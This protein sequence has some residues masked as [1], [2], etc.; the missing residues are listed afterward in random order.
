MI[1]TLQLLF[2]IVAVIISVHQ[3][4]FT[5][6][7]PDQTAPVFRQPPAD[8][9]VCAGAIP[10]PAPLNAIDECEGFLIAFSTDDTTTINGLCNGGIIKR[11]WRV[12]DSKGNTT[13]YNQT[14]RVSP[15]LAPPT[16]SANLSETIEFVGSNNFGRWVI[17]KQNDIIINATDDCSVSNI[18][19]NAPTIFNQCGSTLVTFTLEDECGKTADFQVR[20]TLRDT[21]KP[22]FDNL[23]KDTTISC[24]AGRPP[25][26][27]VTA[28]KNGVPVNVQFQQ[29]DR[30]LG[31]SPCNNYQIIRTWTASDGCGNTFVGVQTITVVDDQAPTFTT[32]PNRM[33]DCNEDYTDVD[34]TGSPTNVS[35]NCNPN[36]VTIN[37]QD[38][39]SLVQQGR[40]VERTWIARD[41]C[42]N[43]RRQMQVITILDTVAP[44]FTVPADIVVDCGQLADLN[45]TG[46]PTMV[47]DNCTAVPTVNYEDVFTAGSCASGGAIQRIWQV[48][49]EAGNKTEKIQRISLDDKIPPTITT[50]A[51]DRTVSCGMA[52][53]SDVLFTEWINQRAGAV[54]VDNCSSITNLT[55]VAYNAGTTNP[56]SLSNADCPLGGSKV[57]RQQTVDFIVQDE[58][59]NRDTTRA[60]FTVVDDIAPVFVYCPPDTTI[61]NLQGLCTTDYVLASPVVEER[62]ATFSGNYNRTLTVPVFSDAPNNRDVPVNP[63]RLS[64]PIILSPSFASDDVRLSIRLINIDG[65]QGPEYFNVLLEDGSIVGRTNNTPAQCGSS[66]TVF[67]NISATQI[68]QS[69][70]SN[71]LVTFFLVPNIVEGQPGRFSVNDICGGSSVEAT[72][73]FK[74]LTPKDIRYEYQINDGERLLFIPP[75]PIIE[76]LDAGI[77]TI[78]YYAIDCA[79]NTSTCSYQ[80]TVL[81]V[82]A[83]VITCP[84]DVALP[85]GDSCLASYQLP[86]P[87]S[88]TDNCGVGKTSSLTLPMDTTSAL[89][90]FS[91]DPD[92][93]DYLADSKTFV[94]QNVSPNALSSATLTI[95]VRADLDNVYGFF[96]I[97]GDDGIP[98]TNTILGQSNV[99]FGDCSQFSQTIIEIPAEVYNEWAADGRI[100]ITAY[101]N[102]AIP[103]PPGGRGDGINPCDPTVVLNDGDNDGVSMMFA[104]LAFS[105]A[106]YTYFTKGAT[107]ISPTKIGLNAVLPELQFAAGVT[108]V[109]YIVE[110]VNKNQDTCSF[111]ITVEDKEPPVARCGSATVTVNPSGTLVE[112]I[113]IAD[114]DLGS[115][116]NCAID[117]MFL[118]PSVFD[119]Q[120]IGRDLVDVT[121]TVIDKS[122]NSA[123]CQA[124]IRIIT[125]SPEPS[126]F[127]PP[128]GT[129][130]LF[131]FA[132]PPAAVGNNIYT[133]RWSGPNGFASNLANPILTNVRERNAGS[134]QVTITGLT[135]CTATGIVEVAISNV[136]STPEITVPQAICFG[137]EIRLSSTTT[138]QG[139]NAIYRWYTGTVDNSM[140]IGTTN[141]PSLILGTLPVGTYNYFLTIEIN[142]CISAAS[143]IKTLQVIETPT[144]IIANANPE[145][146]CE[147]ELIKL[148]TFVAG[149]DL[150]YQWSGPNGF[151]SA[152]QNPAVIQNTTTNNAGVYQLIVSRG[153]CVSEPATTV[154]AIRAKPNQPVLSYG[155]AVCEGGEITLRT[156]INNANAYHWQT[157]NQAEQ[158]TVENAL[159]LRNI[160][161]QLAGNWRVYVTSGGCRSDL[162]NPL[163]VII[164]PNPNLV[165][166]ANKVC[167]NSTLQ[168][169]ASPILDGA[170]YQWTGPNGYAAV[171][172]APTIENVSAANA[173]TYFC[174]ITTQEGCTNT[175][176]TVV[177]IAP[178]IRITGISN[179]GGGECLTGTKDVRLAVAVFPLDNGTY[180]YLWEGPNGFISTDSLPIIPN[181]TASNSGSYTVVVT[182]ASGCSSERRTTTVSLKSAP[183]TPTTPRLSD[184]TRPPFCEGSNITLETSPYMGTEVEYKWLTPRGTRTTTVPTLNI[185]SSTINDD[186]EYAVIVSVDGCESRQ[187]GV[188]PIRVGAKPQISA[189]SNSPICEG[190][191]LRLEA[192][193]I[194][195]A[196]YRWEGPSGL[197]ASGANPVFQMVTPDI[198]N[199]TYRVQA[200]LNG[201][202]SE[203]VAVEVV[204]NNLP[205]LPIALSN[206]PICVGEDNAVLRLAVAAINT[207]AGANYIWYNSNLEPISEPISN[208]VLNI[209]DFSPYPEGRNSFFVEAR[210]KGCSSGISLPTNVILNKIPQNRAFAGEDIAVCQAQSIRLEATLPSIG[211]GK[212]TQTS[213]NPTGI[214]ISNPDDPRTTVS[215][216]SGSGSYTFQWTL[217]NGACMNYSS[218]EV[219]IFLNLDEAADAGEMIDTCSVGSLLLNA[220]RPAI[221][222][223]FW[224]QSTIQSALGVRIEE[225]NNPNSRVSGLQ[226]GN[227]YIFTWNISG[228]T[229][230]ITTDDLVVIVSNGFAFAGN[231]FN[232]CGNGCTKLNAAAPPTDFGRWSSSNPN[233]RF[234]AISNPKTEVCGL[235]VGRNT[236]IW[237]VDNAVCGDRSRDTVTVNYQPLALAQPDTIIVPFGQRADFDVTAND[238]FV[239]EAFS[240]RIIDSPM[241]GTVESLGS[242][243][244]RYQAPALFSGTDAFT[245]EICTVGC[246]CSEALVLVRIGADV[247]CKVPSV[248]TPNNDNINDTFVIPCL[249]DDVK[250]PNNEVIIYNGWG[251]EVFRAKSYKNNW[252]GTYN[253]EDLPD[254]SYFYV[255]NFGD[256]SKPITG[257]LVIQR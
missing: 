18:F 2:R 242:G 130:T 132:N 131:L 79:G 224:T 255:I 149:A 235:S 128:C 228:S 220:K 20:Y 210:L 3:I 216:L 155:G 133:Y 9:T 175:S 240:I 7:N 201:C 170:L 197:T 96:I 223:G 85:L 116:D 167:E 57:I 188:S 150:T 225:P 118:T 165:I 127:I 49:D 120:F 70:G 73:S 67:T 196:T 1:K 26:P 177:E 102:D 11:T 109:F 66:E 214:V 252:Q 84:N 193:F 47:M 222:S 123:T 203:Q 64:F 30:P 158:I 78:T 21:I 139:Q 209:T 87:N 72:L 4:S 195:N 143:V 8:T 25:V 134:Y 234:N 88:I 124:P 122:G 184:I 99:T 153:S 22:T 6:C 173:G 82:D 125:A 140:L 62:C 91:F 31:G 119:C 29:V 36:S 98:L 207:T 247:A 121:L 5:Q 92:L 148:E 248:I 166:S 80:A 54:A 200:I 58:C 45:F 34:I 221:G 191:S 189:F 74:T 97:V 12:S 160:N 83:P 103:I 146:I 77:N 156:N 215:G 212:W 32:P 219:T 135:G 169:T 182:N 90:T 86:L 162:S 145:P 227:Q 76:T 107:E 226:P 171:G 186:G 250:F 152:A 154:I 42:G 10:I 15:D 232:D 174:R 75:S 13:T 16:T 147:G 254:G 28:S 256:G 35:D 244:I 23:P 55:W 151:M 236:L 27:V 211:T 41:G 48:K 202:P 176:S 14:I 69:A 106:E 198:H 192:D 111:T 179:S 17:E 194:P 213:G 172:I 68:N 229:C 253:G 180:R 206:G 101:S 51:K 187:S 185:Q 239:N 137:E 38:Q 43:E 60:T 63:V 71:S 40:Q 115:T 138:P 113:S 110:D 164:N 199:G 19:N 94:F 114:I 50:P 117:T 233:I 241:E 246:D 136:P 81:D 126:F 56:P 53:P 37:F 243:I 100:E 249:I 112:S 59:G 204:V 178:S 208:L 217:S 168:L 104:T 251:D 46:R 257:F 245:Y 95:S 39:V 65:E 93:D 105:N 230:G 205:N 238:N 218:D 89:L 52:I 190:T 24:A 108:E 231:D 44:T 237:T 181:A 157:P 161:P 183:E 144:A 159:T 142:S 129:D 141:T 163:N 61:K 33:L